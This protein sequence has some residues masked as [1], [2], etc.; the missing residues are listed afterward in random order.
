M[1]TNAV[2]VWLVAHRTEDNIIRAHSGLDMTDSFHCIE[3]YIT[4]TKI[5][6]ISICFPILA[7][8]NCQSANLS[9]MIIITSDR[10]D[11]LTKILY[12]LNRFIWASFNLIDYV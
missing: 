9:Y 11:G 10:G 5:A 4:F 6:T 7:L 1:A 8:K 3:V 12:L 2:N